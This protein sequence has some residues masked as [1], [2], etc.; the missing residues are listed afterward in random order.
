MVLEL[1]NLAYDVVGKTLAVPELKLCLSTK[2]TW[3]MSHL[4]AFYL[5]FT[6]SSYCF[7]VVDRFVS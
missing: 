6:C 5:Y 2:C 7:K 3:S 1:E 4:S